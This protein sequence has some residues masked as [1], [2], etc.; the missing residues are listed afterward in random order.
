MLGFKSFDAAQATIAGTGLMH[1]LKKRQIVV[2]N[3]LARGLL[4]EAVDKILQ[5]R[6][7]SR[8]LH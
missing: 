4:M 2:K 5:W 3:G 1:M 8:S 7:C 6:D